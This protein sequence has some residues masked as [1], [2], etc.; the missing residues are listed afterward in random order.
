M[1]LEINI[2]ND[3]SLET[4]NK[5]NVF[6]HWGES[7]SL[8]TFTVPDLKTKKVVGY[9]NVYGIGSPSIGLLTLGAGATNGIVKQGGSWY[10]DK[11]SQAGYFALGTIT[12]TGYERVTNDVSTSVI[13]NQ[14]ISVTMDQRRLQRV[15]EH[16]HF[17][18]STRADDTFG[19]HSALSYDRYLVDYSNAT[20]R[21]NPWTPVG[22]LQ[23]EHKH[24][25]S[26]QAISEPTVATYDV[27][28]WNAGADGTGSICLLYT[29]DAADE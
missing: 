2:G 3:G 1:D 5:D 21:L 20:A 16:D 12:T 26:K 15:P 10:F 4:I 29:S 24:G 28:D 8:G 14:K 22:G 7:R 9:G 11:G 27:Y 25:L 23:Y 6:E 19:W 18:Y 17:I 13:G